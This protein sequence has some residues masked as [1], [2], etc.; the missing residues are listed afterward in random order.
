MDLI[1]ILSYLIRF[2][3]YSLLLFFAIY[4]PI[5][6]AYSCSRLGTKL[7]YLLWKFVISYPVLLFTGLLSPFFLLR[8]RNVMNARLTAWFL[9]KISYITNSTWE[10]RGANIAGLDQGAV[11]CCNHQSA[12]DIFGKL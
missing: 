10:L 7:H 12:V 8:P 5:L 2:Y 3:L 1:P 9:R 11:I 6:L 4:I